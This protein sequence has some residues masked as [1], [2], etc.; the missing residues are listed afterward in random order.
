MRNLSMFE[1]IAALVIRRGWIVVVGWVLFLAVLRSVAPYWDQVS[2]DDDVRFFPPGY[3]SVVGQELLERGFPDDAS[4]S[5]VVVISERR[6][7]RLGKDD[8]AYVDR[9]TAT[10]NRAREQD[11]SL[12]IKKVETYRSP[13][14]GPRLVGT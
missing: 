13:V 14:I 12:G 4:S 5:Q 3:P 11:P 2:K 7:G 8:Y 6:Q 10:L 9:V 1:S